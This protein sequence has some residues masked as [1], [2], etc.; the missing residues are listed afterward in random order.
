MMPASISSAVTLSL[1]FRS[2]SPALAIVMYSAPPPMLGDYVRPTA[3][4]RNLRMAVAPGLFFAS[5][6]SLAVEGQSEFRTKVVAALREVEV[7]RQRL[8]VERVAAEF[9][10]FLV[11]CHG[12][13]F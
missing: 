2:L 3:R 1:T 4:E 13:L 6:G 11:G 9:C 8:G 7:S 10:R 5:K 12:D